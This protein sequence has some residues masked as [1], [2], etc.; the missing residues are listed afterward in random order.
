MR[1][2]H[3][4]TSKHWDQATIFWQIDTHNQIRTGKVILYNS[5]TNKRVKTPFNRIAGTQSATHPPSI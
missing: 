3:I 4:G 2:Y 5:K 1:L